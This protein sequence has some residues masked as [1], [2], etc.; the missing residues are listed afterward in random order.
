MIETDPTLQKLQTRRQPALVGARPGAEVDDLHD[1][2]ETTA[3]DQVVDQLG[4]E[5]AEG[6]GPGGGVGGRAGGEPSW[7]NIG[8]CRRYR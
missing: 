8:L 3:V 2:A 1:A 4:E 6:G 7:V 5:A